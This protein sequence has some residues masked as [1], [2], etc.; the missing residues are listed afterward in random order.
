VKSSRP[1]GLRPGAA[2][3]LLELMETQDAVLSGAAAEICQPEALSLR[4]AG[5]L[6]A[7]GH[8]D[9]SASLADHHDVPVPL[10]SSEAGPSYFSATAGLTAVPA[11]RLVLYRVQ[12]AVAFRMI[13]ARLRLVAA[14]PLIE[15]IRG[16][17]WELGDARLGNGSQH[18]PIWFARRLW[19]PMIR[20]ALETALQARPHIRTCVILTSTGPARIPPMT[21][22]GALVVP[23]LDVMTLPDDI[24]VN[25][26]ILAARLGSAP[27]SERKRPISLSPDGTTL[28]I[29]G[30]TISFRSKRQIE[31]IRHLVAAHDQ[32]T[33]VRAADVTSLGSLN[34]LFGAKKWETLSLNLKSD[35]QTWGFEV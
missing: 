19:D 13:T 35:G 9:V 23:I 20:R 18:V 34:R 29:N 32:G 11:E 14:T 33:R 10:I 28:E 12:Y 30:R 7:D 15:L 5:F 25:P 24:R 31:A 2:R 3:L 1:V 8:E 4:A 27:Q 21:F 17:V 16:S 6:S 22:S 26:E